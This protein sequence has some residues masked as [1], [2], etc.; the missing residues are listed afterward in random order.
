[1]EP[2]IQSVRAFSRVVAERVGTFTDHFLG[3]GRPYGESRVLWEIGAGADIRELRGRLGLDSGYVTRVMQS[4]Q[5]QGLVLIEPSRRDGRVRHVRLTRPGR[6]ERAELERRSDEK[7]KSLL[8]PLSE[9]QRAELVAAMSTVE[10]LLMASLVTFAVEDPR[11][12]EARWCIGQYFAELNVRFESGFDPGRS[13]PAEAQELTPP[14]G[15]LMIA[16]LR[17]RPV[18]CGALKFHR[19]KPAELKR[20]WIAPETRGV[21]IGRRLLVELERYA[22][23]AGAR[24]IRLE[25]NGSL[26]EAIALYRTSGY[27]EVPA[28]NHE[29][30]AHHWFEKVL[31]RGG[32]RPR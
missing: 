9:P 4:L 17:G 14:A 30:Y 23:E 20:M 21:G 32:S 7:A 12:R 3:S 2:Q 16:R 31:G 13:I 26:T 1:M 24:V 29:L 22:K 6:R 28:F 27:R 15:A 10:R 19:G 11:T 25:T 5:A 8:D 18:G